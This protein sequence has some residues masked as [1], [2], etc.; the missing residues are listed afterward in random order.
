[1]GRSTRNSSRNNPIREFNLAVRNL[2]R[3]IDRL[4]RLCSEDHEELNQFLR[5]VTDSA[6]AIAEGILARPQMRERNEAD[7][8][9]NFT[10]VYTL[11]GESRLG[12]EPED[13]RPGMG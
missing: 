8:R 9:Q 5:M 3:A 13:R 10:P 2:A 12:H 4:T 11:E 1:M 7:E 6:P